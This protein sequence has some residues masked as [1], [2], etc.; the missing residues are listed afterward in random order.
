MLGS[1]VFAFEPT[2][3]DSDISWMPGPS[4]VTVTALGVGGGGVGGIRS[5]AAMPNQPEARID[6]CTASKGG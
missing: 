5:Q 1:P 3:G 6:F 4:C 2:T